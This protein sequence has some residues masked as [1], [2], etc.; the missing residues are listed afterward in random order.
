MSGR[1]AGCTSILIATHAISE[2][3][4]GGNLEQVA[5]TDSPVTV[6]GPWV[7]HLDADASMARQCIVI[8]QS[9]HRI[10]FDRIATFGRPGLVVAKYAAVEAPDTI[11]TPDMSTLKNDCFVRSLLYC[12]YVTFFPGELQAT[13]TKDNLGLF[14]TRA[15]TSLLE[16]FSEFPERSLDTS[17]SNCIWGLLGW[18]ALSNV[19][20]QSEIICEFLFVDSV[21]DASDSSFDSTSY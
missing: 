10:I 19:I 6:C 3:I 18:L 21:E 12:A 7:I 13:S 11:F 8:N 5:P 2:L 15:E 17:S 4:F 20:D 16:R 14:E 9:F 1:L